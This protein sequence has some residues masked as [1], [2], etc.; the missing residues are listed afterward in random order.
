[1]SERAY[2][3]L[4]CGHQAPAPPPSPTNGD[5]EVMPP[6]V[7]CPVCGVPRRWQGYTPDE[8]HEFS[9]ADVLEVIE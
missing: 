9:L 8:A 3:D 2:Y 5:A 1:M 4:A 7:E 6:F